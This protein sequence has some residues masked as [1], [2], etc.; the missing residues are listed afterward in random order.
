MDVSG[1]VVDDEDERV[2]THEHAESATLQPSDDMVYTRQPKTVC[3]FTFRPYPH[4]RTVRQVR[5]D[6]EKWEHRQRPVI[7]AICVALSCIGLVL[8]LHGLFLE[9]STEFIFVVAFVVLF[10]LVSWFSPE[11]FPKM[12]RQRTITEISLEQ[13]RPSVLHL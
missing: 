3:C 4:G 6:Y 10:A 2:L 13:S 5:E 11:C 7:Y 1:V 9:D 8:K 12:P